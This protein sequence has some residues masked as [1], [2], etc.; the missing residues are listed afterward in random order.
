MFICSF[1]Y[2]YIFFCPFTHSTIAFEKVKCVRDCGCVQI[3]QFKPSFQSSDLYLVV[4]VNGFRSEVTNHHRLLVNVLQTKTEKLVRTCVQAFCY[5]MTKSVCKGNLKGAG[6]YFFY[7]SCSSMFNHNGRVA[8]FVFFLINFTGRRR[9]NY[10]KK[11]K[12]KHAS[13]TALRI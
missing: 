6:L 8:L 2:I 5:V 13:L 9:G 1:H 11:E 12:R 3:F 10:R 4:I 7:K